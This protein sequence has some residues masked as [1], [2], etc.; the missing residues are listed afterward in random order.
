MIN[1]GS[2]RYGTGKSRK[3]S[4][5]TG[6]ADQIARDLG[7]ALHDAVDWRREQRRSRSAGAAGDLCS[8]KD[9]MVFSWPGYVPEPELATQDDFRLHS[10]T[11]LDC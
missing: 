7:Q 5:P 6:A 9:L 3:W 2:P 10:E 4:S 8:P 1:Q 11:A